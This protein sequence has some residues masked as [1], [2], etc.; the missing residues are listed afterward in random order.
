MSARRLALAAVLALNL[1]PLPAVAEQP[2]KA[3]DEAAVL[4]SA[5]SGCHGSAASASAIPSL[6]ALTADDL[7]TRFRR[8]KNESEESSAMH[9]LARGYS[10]DQIEAIANF[11]AESE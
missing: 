11:L 9:R 4:A 3:L 1:S 7:A 10:D 5:C 2:A 8:Y 6:Q